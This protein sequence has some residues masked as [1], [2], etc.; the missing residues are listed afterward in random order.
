MRV[1]LDE[2]L[3]R[4]LAGYLD[5][6]QVTTVVE[7]GFSGLSNGQLLTAIQEE[8]DAFVTIDSNLQHQQAI[9]NRPIRVIV[10][11]SISNRLDDLVP[12]VPSMVAALERASEGVVAYAE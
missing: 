10:V 4:R 5:G 12:L 7:A 8:F 3:P 1:I 9:G 2:C 6:H 11:R